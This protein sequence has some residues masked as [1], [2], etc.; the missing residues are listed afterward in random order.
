MGYYK[1]TCVEKGSCPKCKGTLN[2]GKI[3]HVEELKSE[4][5]VINVNCTDC[6][7]GGQEVFKLT[8]TKTRTKVKD[9]TTF[10]FAA[11]AGKAQLKAMND[12]ND[13][14]KETH[15]SEDFSVVE[16]VRLLSRDDSLY[17][18][19]GTLKHND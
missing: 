2:Y 7:Y 19:D 18:K 12:Y 15:P 8:Y 11:L 9:K 13:G 5:A 6:G 1:E 10:P 14:W 17:F 16:L 3:E 4:G